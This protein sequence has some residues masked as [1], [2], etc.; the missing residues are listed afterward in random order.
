[1]DESVF[2]FSEGGRQIALSPIHSPLPQ[3]N[4]PADSPSSSPLQRASHST[5]MG[6]VKPLTMLHN[7]QPLKMSETL[8]EKR[9]KA[10]VIS[11]EP[12]IVKP[13]SILT[14]KYSTN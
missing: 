11:K 7:L 3:A 13:P 9:D 1:M 8:E 2:V 10:A 5:P 4:S 6:A 14:R 12:K